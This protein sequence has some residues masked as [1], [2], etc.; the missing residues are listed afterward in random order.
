MSFSTRQILP[1]ADLNSAF[2]GKQDVFVA[3]VKSAPYHAKG[4]GTDDYPAFN[5]AQNALSAAGGGILFVPPG[6]YNCISGSIKPPSNTILEGAGIDA[7]TILNNVQTFPDD[8]TISIYGTMTGV[9]TNWPGTNT[10]YPINAPTIGDNKVTTT[11][12]ADAGNFPNGTIIFISGGLH[13]T[14][15][16]YPGWH[17]T[18]LSSNPATGVITLAETLPFGGSQITTVQ[19]ILSLKQNIAI[20]DMT[21]ATGKASAIGCFVAKNILIENVKGIPGVAGVLTGPGMALGVCRNSMF[22]NCRTEQ[23]VGPIE[24]FVASDSY[25]DGCHL[26]NS[27]I[28]VDGGCFD[29]GVINNYI[30]AP[31]QSGANAHAILLAEYGQRLRVI[32]NTI[33]GVP[34]GFAGIYGPPFPDANR[35]YSAI[36]ND[37]SGA[38]YS[39]GN[40][41]ILG[42]FAAIDANHL[43]NLQTGIAPDNNAPVFWGVNTF[44]NVLHHITNDGLFGANTNWRLRPA[45]GLKNMTTATATPSVIGA[46][47]YQLF[48]AA[49][50]TITNFLGAEIGDEITVFLADGNTTFQ[51]SGVLQLKGAVDYHP[52]A[53]VTMKFLM[54]AGGPNWTEVSRS[55]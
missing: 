41:G 30:K 18:V 29:C 34:D 16:W 24:L 52:I 19:K 50:Q 23:G 32:G 47:T 5:M 20:R 49:P 27:S 28:V 25:I 6:N 53:N 46:G 45:G 12:A 43:A 40:T 39:S 9:N 10:T 36:G 21:V 42:A 11:V 14:S 17:T 1:A 51:Q 3:D 2:D 8:Q 26:T 4:D 13:S 48:N 55:A 44:D 54:T 22:R 33:T 35:Y 38:V 7:T 31:Q 15:F 37:I